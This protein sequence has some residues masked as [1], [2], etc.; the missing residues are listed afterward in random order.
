VNVLTGGRKRLTREK[1]QA[2]EAMDEFL[3]LV[4]EP[5]AGTPLQTEKL[6]LSNDVPIR[7]AST[8]LIVHGRPSSLGCRPSMYIVTSGKGNLI[9]EQDGQREVM[10]NP[11]NRFLEAEVVYP[12]VP[13]TYTV[14]E[15]LQYNCTGM[16]G[17][18]RK[19][20]SGVF[21]VRIGEVT[22]VQMP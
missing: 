13:G 4:G 20:A 14:V 17:F 22:H 1:R 7:I 8:G 2:E 6:Q 15:V 18:W 21:T 12:L 5:Q 3:R 10:Q 16:G 19:G 11:E 9:L